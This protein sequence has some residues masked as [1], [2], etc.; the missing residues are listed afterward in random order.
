MAGAPYIQLVSVHTRVVDLFHTSRELVPSLSFFI[1]IYQIF[2]SMCLPCRIVQNPSTLYTQ[3]PV[4]AFPSCHIASRWCM[5]CK[6]TIYLYSAYAM[7]ILVSILFH[8]DLMIINPHLTRPTS[9]HGYSHR[10]SRT[11]IFHYH[12]Y[13]TYRYMRYLRLIQCCLFFF[14]S[15]WSSR[16]RA[17]TLDPLWLD[18]PKGQ[19]TIC[20][21]FLKWY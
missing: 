7:R 11:P 6:P 2:S 19:F 9:M 16:I 15:P 8:L 18:F 3:I 1:T 4:F 10:I 13:Q 5:S 21:L 17:G 12:I 14:F 20:S